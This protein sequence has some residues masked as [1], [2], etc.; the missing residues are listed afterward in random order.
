[1]LVS[2]QNVKCSSKYN[3]KYQLFLLQKCVYAIFNDQSFNDTLTNDIV[4]F[5]ELDRE[6]YKSHWCIHTFIP[7]FLKWTL[8]FLNLELSTNANRGFSL[9]SK[10][11]N[12]KQCIS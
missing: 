8:P 2:G 1:M 4:S 5:K 11:H 6:V 3:I 10:Q 12:G 9:K 7:E